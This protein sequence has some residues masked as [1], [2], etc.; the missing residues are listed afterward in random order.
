MV[1]KKQP[2]RTIFDVAK[3]GKGG[4]PASAT[5]RPVIVTNRPVITDPMVTEPQ[6]TPVLPAVKPSKKIIITPLHQNIVPE[7]D[8]PKAETPPSEI[9]SIKTPPTKAPLAESSTA[10]NTVESPMAEAKPDAEA[11][12]I[13]ATPPEGFPEPV[14]DAALVPGD[15]PGVPAEPDE[16]D[17]ESELARKRAA[18]LQ[19]MIDDEEYFLPIKTVEERRSRKVAIFGLLLIILLAAAWYDIALDASLLPNTYDLPHTSFFTVK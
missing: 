16:R 5:T 1:K 8:Q 9:T 6:L 15:A 4:L 2:A 7:T 18:R 14:A 19:K 10:E 13:S 11:P 3:P 12:K 17:A